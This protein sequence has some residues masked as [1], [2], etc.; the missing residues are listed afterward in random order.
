MNIYIALAIVS[1]LYAGVM[2]LL[3]RSKYEAGPSSPL[4]RIDTSTIKGRKA[5]IAM[6]QKLAAEARKSAEG[7]IER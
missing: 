1:A 3:C 2:A 4:D 7:E 6:C 5:Y